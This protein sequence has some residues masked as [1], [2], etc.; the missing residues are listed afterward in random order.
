MRPDF[1]KVIL[2]HSIISEESSTA[3]A[4]KHREF[5]IKGVLFVLTIDLVSS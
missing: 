5:N 1:L 2:Q 4:I 3:F